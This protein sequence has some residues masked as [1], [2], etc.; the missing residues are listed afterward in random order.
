[1]EGVAYLHQQ[2][3]AHRD[4][5][6]QNIMVDKENEVHVMDFNV[7]FQKRDKAKPFSLMTKTGTVA[8]SAPEIFS[9][10]IYD[11]RVDV[12]SAG[13]VLYMM[14]TGHQPFEDD[15]IAKLVEKI[16]HSDIDF[17]E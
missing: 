2:G 13:V 5:K 7:A 16:V 10:P 17:E 11:E 14:M 15:N 4:L 8:F 12:W 9:Q 6:P 3:I 1:M